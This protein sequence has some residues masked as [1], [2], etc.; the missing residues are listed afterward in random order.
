MEL[1]IE[2]EELIVTKS[3]TRNR[4]KKIKKIKS[5]W[6]LSSRFLYIVY[7][8][9]LINA[10]VYILTDIFLRIYFNRDFMNMIA[11][12]VNVSIFCLIYLI[13]IGIRNLEVTGYMATI[14]ANYLPIEDQDIPKRA[15]DMINTE[16]NKALEISSSA[17]PLPEDI[18]PSGWG[19]KGT[20]Y[21]NIHFQTAIVQSSSLLEATVLKYNEHLVR[22]PYMTIRQYINILAN[23]KLIN[24][25]IGLCYVNNYE[26]ACYSTDEIKEDEYE[27]TMKLLALLLKKMQS[28]RNHKNKKK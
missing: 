26:H 11:L 25:D 10:I 18:Q 2:N 9:I 15:S 27:E 21:E 6:T 23:N 12:G 8:F 1:D 16:L 13:T 20:M 14:P 5:K 17:E 3:K 28:K 7:S 19:K 24:R 4:I 22:E